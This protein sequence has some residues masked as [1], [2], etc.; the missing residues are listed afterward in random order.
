MVFGLPVVVMLALPSMMP[1]L[2]PGVPVTVRLTVA[3]QSSHFSVTVCVG[4]VRIFFAGIAASE[5]GF[6]AFVLRI[7][8]F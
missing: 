7:V 8:R 4:V 3:P 2:L 6:R 1:P 5:A